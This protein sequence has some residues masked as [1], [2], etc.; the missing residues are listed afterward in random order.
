MRLNKTPVSL[1]IGVLLIAQLSLA[2]EMNGEHVPGRLLVQLRAGTDRSTVS[3]V[4]ARVGA[5][6]QKQV[7]QIHLSVLQVPES[8]ATGISTALMRTGLFTFVEPD[9]VAHSAQTVVD[10]NDP[11]FSSQWHLATIQSPSGWALTTGVTSVPI[12]IIDSGVDGTHPD[13]ATKLIPGWNFLTGTSNTAD[14]LGHGTAVAGTAA[15][16]TD[17]ATG[18][19]GVSWGNPI[20]P[21]VVLNS[22]DYASYS[23]IANAITYAADQG[24]RVM[25]ISIGGSSASSTLQS[26]VDYAWNKGAVIFA[27]AMNNSTSAPY[28]PAA[29]T[30]VVAVSATDQNDNLASFSDYGSWIDLSAPGTSILTTMMGGSYGYWQGTSFSSPIAAATAAL[31]L[32]LRPTLSNSSLVALLEQN[33]DDLGTPGWDQYFGYG[34]INV[35]KAVTAASGLT[36]DT[37]PP[38]VSIS[39]PASGATVSG[40]IEIQGTATDNVGVTAIQFYVDS[41]LV[42]SATSSPFAFSWST[43][44]VAN[45]SHTLMVEASDAAG[46]VG[47]ASVSVTVNNPTVT[48]TT[49]PTV[50]ITNPVNG[51]TVSGTTVQIAVSATDNVGVTQV[52]I[53]VDNV[54]KCADSSAPYTCNWNIKKTSKGSHVI[55][56]HAWDAAGN[57]GSATPVTVTK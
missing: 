37:T 18:V 8:A 39:S 38:T 56:A 52:T 30:N 47:T 49:P 54:L 4:L 53:Y 45:G 21:L 33:S 13:L 22:S 16:A 41:H 40:T 2:Q 5:K 27:S 36:V 11:D 12:A 51:S 23:D 34:R 7:P 46:N 14:D 32:S 9:G 3:R 25:N 57:V 43:T 44:G 20:M 17:N 15:A 6:L 1:A 55:T 24:V 48:D 35:Y 31:V 26:A 29:C 10:P 50:S 19:A 28:Y 42:T